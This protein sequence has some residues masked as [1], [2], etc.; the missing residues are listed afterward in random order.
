VEKK[1][2]IQH[3]MSDEFQDVLKVFIPLADF[4][5]HPGSVPCQEPDCSHF[6]NNFTKEIFFHASEVPLE[7]S[8]SSPVGRCS[9]ATRGPDA[10]DRG[11]KK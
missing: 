1:F 11:Q 8:M 9:S 10:Y 6:L 3:Q 7:M 4:Q 2:N 5:F